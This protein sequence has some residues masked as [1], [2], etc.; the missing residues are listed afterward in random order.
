MGAAVKSIPATE[1]PEQPRPPRR[2]RSRKLFEP[3]LVQQALKQ[4]FVMLR[5]EIQWSNPVMFVVEIGAVLTFLFIVQVQ[6]LVSTSASQVPITYFVALD[7]WLFLTVLFANFATALAEARGK[8]QAESLRRTRGETPAFRIRG[9]S[10]EEVL[11]TDL[12]P[13]DQVVVAAGQVIPSDG[14]II[15]GIASVDESAITG[16]S[17]PVIREAGGDRSGVTGGTRVISDRIVVKITALPG[18]SFLDRMIA[19]V[20]GAVRQ[21]TPNEI[22]LTLALSGLSLAF[23][24]VV[25][26]LWPMAWNA[27]QY[28]MGYLGISEP[29][30]SL[31]HR[32]SNAG[33]LIG[34]PDTYDD[35]RTARRD[36][37]CRYGSRAPSQHYCEER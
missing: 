34:L 5:P 7:V 24:I 25:I 28:M 9:E 33:S 6:A 27:E 22:A 31:R 12:K 17:A 18:Q 15:Q 10:M 37:N 23:L 26:P 2:S 13:G 1:T 20:E 3:E 35:R 21:K 8:A 19:L 36:R 32:R 11:S 4:S 29:L 14:E 16:E 30:K